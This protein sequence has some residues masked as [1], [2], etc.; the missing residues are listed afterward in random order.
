MQ[1]FA[2]QDLPRSLFGLMELTRTDRAF[3]AAAQLPPDAALKWK[4]EAAVVA[5]TEG[6][7]VAAQYIVDAVKARCPLRKHK[8]DP[9]WESMLIR[10]ARAGA[11]ANC[12]R[13]IKIAVYEQ[14][15]YRFFYKNRFP[16]HRIIEEAFEQFWN[17]WSRQ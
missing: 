6:N 10:I 5:A 16:G 13:C 17:T 14:H 11:A 2:L 8:R 4:R 9:R 1:T 7:P 15:D 3:L 12:G